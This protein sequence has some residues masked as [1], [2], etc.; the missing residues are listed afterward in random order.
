MAITLK[1]AREKGKMEQF[2][3]EHEK[4]HPRASKQHFHGVIKAMALKTVKPKR[5]TSRKGSRAD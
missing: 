1:E 4:T 5:G 3:C 2:I